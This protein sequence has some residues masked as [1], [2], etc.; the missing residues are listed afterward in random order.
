MRV[1]TPEQPTMV[2]PGWYPDPHGVAELRWWDGADW[3]EHLHNVIAPAEP[4][5]PAEPEPAEAEPAVAEPVANFPDAQPAAIDPELNFPP[6][7]F[8]VPERST[9][10][11]GNPVYD[12][13]DGTTPT[14]AEESA[15]DPARGSEPAPAETGPPA[16]SASPMHDLFSLTPTGSSPLQVEPL[17]VEPQQFQPQYAEPQYA[18]PQ[19]IEP[20]LIDPSTQQDVEHAAPSELAPVGSPEPLPSRRELRERGETFAEPVESAPQVETEP[21][22]EAAELIEATLPVEATLQAPV[23][24]TSVPTSFDWT[25]DGPVDSS[26]VT[27]DAVLTIPEPAPLIPDPAA[28]PVQPES[29]DTAFPARATVPATPSSDF[30]SFATAAPIAAHTGQDAPADSVWAPA[31]PSVLPD[32]EIPLPTLRS[33][34][35][36][37][38]LIAFMPLIAGALSLGAVKGAENYPRYAPAGASWW[39]LVVVVLV[40]LYIVTL[41]LAFIDR[42]KL[43]S[44]GHYFPASWFWAFATAPAYLIARTFAIK[45]ETG[46][47][48]LQLWIWIFLTVVV[49]GAY[50]AIKLL[51]P[52]LV[53]AY[54]L[55]FPSTL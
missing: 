55:P 10:D 35:I 12:L 13:G 4:A 22:V 42:R 20:Q 53:S 52:D 49:I 38:W 37:G 11:F 41:L 34:T 54:A 46:R 31:E 26:T 48:P 32:T 3:T 9:N 18:E 25:V 43:D 28:N 51:A 8:Q 44:I 50:S 21:P 14:S 33:S 6:P 24:D 1:M 16:D 27:D 47:M 7:A 40:I 29:D 23:F 15:P 17:Q 39:V 30:S 45:R 2:P 5:T 36:S 19:W